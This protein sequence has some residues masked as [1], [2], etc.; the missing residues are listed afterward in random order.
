[1]IKRFLTSLLERRRKKAHI[2]WL[3]WILVDRNA[4]AVH[5]HVETDGIVTCEG[6][7]HRYEQL[8]KLLRE[9]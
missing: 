6:C 7:V 2:K 4:I 3:A 1:M 9:V 5:L 8:Q